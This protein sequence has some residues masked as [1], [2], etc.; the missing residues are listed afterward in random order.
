MSYEAAIASFG[1]DET[2]LAKSFIIS[3]KNTTANWYARLSLRSITSWAQLKEKFPINFQDFHADISTEEYF[4]SYQEYERETL[5]NFFRRFLQL[6]S[7]APEVLDKKSITQ[8]TKA[9]RAGKLHNHLVREHPR[10]L[11]EFYDEFYK[12]SRAEVLYFHK[13]GQ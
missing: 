5:P 7:Q 9:L 6:K 8:A 3:L 1:V 2:T 12:F 10:T 13:L 11:V 4:F